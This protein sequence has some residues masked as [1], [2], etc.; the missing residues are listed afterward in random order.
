MPGRIVFPEKGK[1][2][3]ERFELPATGPRDVRVRTRYS[4]MSIGTETTILHQRYA[5]DTHFAKIFSFPQLK[6]GV[7]AIGEIEEVGNEV[8]NL[9]V[10]ERIFMRMAHG[11]HQVL[12]ATACTPVPNHMD[13][14]SACWCGLA[15]TAFRA[16]WAGRFKAGCHVLII[17]AGPVGQ[18][19]IRW[20]KSERVETITVVD[21]S[22]SRLEHATRG[23]ATM[24]IEGDVADHVDKILSIDSGRGPPVIVDTTG[25]PKV[26]KH[27]LSAAPVFGKVILL[28]DTGYPGRQC[29]TS[30]VM[31]KG[32]TI[33]A[34]HDSHDRD[35][36]TQRRIDEK[37]FECVSDGRFDLSDL[38]TH[39]FSPADCADAYALAD[40]R[41]EQ[42]MGILYD[43][44]KIN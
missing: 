44:S 8:S 39:E 24:V 17:G 16:A 7:Q 19:A 35:G 15:K 14:K 4:L 28:G 25:N 41:R 2:V 37:F 3:L 5:P 31:S 6:T 40:E 10:G 36:W 13:P 23:G 42:V 1:V 12:Q 9:A 27:A 33:Q 38:I 21:M 20:A 30:D 22:S 34:V 32:L 43:W 18:M 29:L 26:F 11:S